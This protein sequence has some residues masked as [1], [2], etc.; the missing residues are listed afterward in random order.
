MSKP[1]IEVIMI[2]VCSGWGFQGNISGLQSVGAWVQVPELDP[3]DFV[4]SLICSSIGDICYRLSCLSSLRLSPADQLFHRDKS[5]PLVVSG[6]SESVES[7]ANIRWAPALQIYNMYNIIYNIYNR[8]PGGG[9]RI[10]SCANIRWAPAL[11]MASIPKAN[12]A[13]VTLFN[14]IQLWHFSIIFNC[15]TLQ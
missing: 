7:C 3:W 12:V 10:Q 5:F 14:N 4:S 13:I 8:Q 1:A 6:F 11:Q 9:E 15:D 2:T